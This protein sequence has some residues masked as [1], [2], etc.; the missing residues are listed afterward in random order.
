MDTKRERAV[1][2][3]VLRTTGMALAVGLGLSAC[4]ASGTVSKSDA[5]KKEAAQLADQLNTRLAEEGLPEVDQ[6]TAR[7][8]YGV[9]GGV[10]CENAGNLQQSLGIFQFGNNA[11]H[12][13]RVVLD[14]TVVA[15]DLAVVETY[16][17]DKVDEFNDVVEELETKETIPDQSS[18]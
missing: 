16:C 15:H 1:R 9:D 11:L 8:L 17:P 6:E 7:A 5:D 14:P 13:R 10:S 2:L 4:S 18:R 12:L 3:A